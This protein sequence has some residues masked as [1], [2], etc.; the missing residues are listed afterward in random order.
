MHESRLDSTEEWAERIHART[1]MSPEVIL[2]ALQVYNREAS[3]R[4]RL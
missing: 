4:E 3:R 2:Q 1:G